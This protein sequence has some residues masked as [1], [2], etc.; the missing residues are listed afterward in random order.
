MVET[1][2]GCPAERTT[3]DLYTPARPANNS[4]SYPYDWAMALF[5]FDGVNSQFRWY[6][7]DTTVPAQITY[8]VDG[9]VT[10][11]GRLFNVAHPD[12]GFDFNVVF[13]N[14][15]TW[16]E[17]SSDATPSSFKA[18]CGGL[19]A[20]YQDWMYY[21][22]QG[23]SSV[24]LTGWGVLSG[25]ALNLNHAPASQYFG[26]QLGEGAN[27]Y[28]ADY[29]LGGWFSYSGTFLYQGEPLMSGMAA[30][31]GDFAFGIDNCPD[32][33][34]V[35][36]WTAIDC[37]GNTTSCSQT[38]LF[39]SPDVVAAPV[40]SAEQTSDNRSNEISIVGI[41]PNPAT[42]RSMITFMSEEAGKLTLEILDM[43]G[44]VVGSLF[45]SEVLA[46]VPYTADFNAEQLSSGLYMVRL[47]SESKFDIERIQIQK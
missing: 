34:I 22:L 2:I 5:G 11:S 10:I 42:N 32:Y 47:S 25:S 26:F 20:N 40:A 41:Q 7:I 12:G 17:W 44:R 35:R 13:A 14:A 43:T 23:G 4:C 29:G 6:Q 15:K 24:E 9:S 38:I 37:S 31:V 16:E 45:N 33:S 27:N 39:T 8:N 46:G 36:T 18:D 3:F 1:C 30:G 19:D 28:N 21:I